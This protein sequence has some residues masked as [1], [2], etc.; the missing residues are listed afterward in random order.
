M[1]AFVVLVAD[2]DVAATAFEATETLL[3]ETEDVLFVCDASVVL[4]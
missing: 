3:F 4:Q 2:C 1:R